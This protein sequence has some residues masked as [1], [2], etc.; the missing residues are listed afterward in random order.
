MK[1]NVVFPTLMGGLGNRMFQVATS[2]AYAQV[3]HKN[4]VLDVLKISPNP[5][6]Q[7][8]YNTSIFKNIPKILTLDPNSCSFIH[9]PGNKAI[10][11]FYLPP[12]DGNVHLFG[13]FQCEKHFGSYREQLKT[14]FELPEIQEKPTTN[15][16]FMHVRRGDY[17]KVSIHGGYDYDLYYGN[18]LDYLSSKFDSLHIYV[19]SN[20]MEWCKSWDLLK[21]YKFEFHFLV[22]NELETLKFMTLCDKG[23]ICAN[24]SFSWWGAYLNDSP[25][26]EVLMPNQWFFEK[27][28]SEYKNE[29][30]FEKCKAFP[31]K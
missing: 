20:D 7:I 23:G 31:C 12:L 18:A 9:E 10:S 28:E 3:N 2:Y 22:L 8:D 11:Y 21:K 6:S 26:K 14:L 16:M 24:S 19:F 1:K 30:A 27:P 13:Y 17:T 5:H 25:Q 4:L 15:S 29:I